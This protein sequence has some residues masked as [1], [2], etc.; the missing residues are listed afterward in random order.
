MTSKMYRE[1]IKVKCLELAYQYLMKKRGQKGKEI[2]YQKI[3]MAQYL[4][5]NNSLEIKEQRKIFEMRNRMTNIHANY[6]TKSEQLCICGEIE[7][8]KHIYE[9]KL[10]NKEEIEV[11]YNDIYESNLKDMKTSTTRSH[12]AACVPI[13]LLGVYRTMQMLS[14]PPFF[15]LK[16]LS[17]FQIS[18]CIIFFLS[19]IIY[20]VI[21]GIF[22]YF[23]G[24]FVF[25]FE[26]LSS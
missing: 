11:N 14:P 21:F 3:E 4:S 7:N 8:M 19:F 20:P 16:G 6:S 23:F 15:Y 22:W 18:S 24:V 13:V 2:I 10:F 26:N 17:F 1:L 25:S 9:C 12:G 5:P